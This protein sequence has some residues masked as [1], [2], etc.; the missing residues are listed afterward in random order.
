MNA[1]D[2]DIRSEYDFTGAVEGKHHRQ[3]WAVQGLIAL[4]DDL[5]DS[6]P[7]AAAVNEALRLLLSI[8]KQIA[9]VA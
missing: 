8:R 7:D 2:D 5:R 3:Y 4:D 1:E 6:F 9:G